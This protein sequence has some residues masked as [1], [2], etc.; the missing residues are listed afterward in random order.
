MGTLKKDINIWGILAIGVGTTLSGGF[1]LLPGLAAKE[2]GSAVILAYLISIIPLI[3]SLLSQI[4]LA[5]AIPRAGG[6]YFFIDRTL[7]PYFGTIGGIG[8]WISLILKVAFALIGMGAYVKLIFPQLEIVSTAIILAILLGILNL[9]GTKSSTTIQFVLSTVLIL[10]L[11]HFISSGAGEINTENYSEMFQTEFDS[12]LSTAGFVFMSYIGITKLISLAEEIKNPGKIL[13]KGIFLSL[14]ISLTIYVL[15]I[16]IMVGVLPFELLS[17]NLTPAAETAKIITGDYGVVIISIAAIL[18]F[19]SVANAGI[20]S[21][22]RYPFAMSRDHLLPKLFRKANS[23]GIPHI[24]IIITV[25]ITIFFIVFTDPTTIAKLASTFLLLIFSI[26]CFSVIVMRESKI[27]SYD[28]SFRSP[29]YPWTQIVGIVS[30]FFL[31]VE[32]GLLPFLFS[33]ILIIFGSMWYKLYVKGNV[34]RTGAIFNIFERLGK[35]KYAGIDYELRDLMKKKGLKKEDPFDKIVADSFVI[36]YKDEVT[37]EEITEQVCD[38]LS[39]EILL[40]K[41]VLVKE[42]LDG[43]RIGATP[44]IEHIALPH[45]IVD[46]LER[47]KMALVR[48]KKGINIKY[49]NPMIDSKEE[50]TVTVKAMFFL[51]SPKNNP[52]Q[53]LRIL[54]RIAGRVEENSFMRDWQNAKTFHELK[55]AMIS[56]ERFLFLKI[57]D[58]DDT[59]ALAGKHINE[60]EFPHSTLI[61]WIKRDNEIIIPDGKTILKENDIL[62]LIGEPDSLSE[63]M[64]IY[65]I[66]RTNY[67]E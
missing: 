58:R 63:I 41:E 50:M 26:L 36:D 27:E 45:L 15:G 12:L 54:A 13:A 32:M 8:T 60:V 6:I 28:P 51:I 23:K 10:I 31:A 44:V 48:S 22:S 14:A 5:T 17:G 57:S 55:I 53:H 49:R 46:G 29:F 2:A 43:S 24:S 11:I 64:G 62:T 19:L 40:P 42:F 38:W 56:N 39:E 18:S 3:P 52:S 7:G 34:L 25:F 33:F 61:A 47:S 35:Y 30:S 20:L 37:F 16:G 9:F 67:F 21:A 1:F 59:I 65:N 4:E 66:Y